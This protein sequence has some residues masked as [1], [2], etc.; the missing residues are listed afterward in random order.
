VFNS[1]CNLLSECGYDSALGAIKE[2][3][4]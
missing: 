2:K 1:L 3:R 4:S